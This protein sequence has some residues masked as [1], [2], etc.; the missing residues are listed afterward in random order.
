MQVV[1]NAQSPPASDPGLRVKGLKDGSLQMSCEDPDHPGQLAAQHVRLALQ[2][3]RASGKG[4]STSSST[5][6]APA[7]GV[8]GKDLARREA[9][10]EGRLARRGAPEGKLDLLVTLDSA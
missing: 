6:S 1:K 2:H 9:G 3:P 4:T 8:Q 7:H 10:R 5:C